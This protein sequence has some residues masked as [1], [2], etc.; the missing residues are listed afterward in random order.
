MAE[1]SGRRGKKQNY[2][3]N[4]Q[5]H[6]EWM[7]RKKLGRPETVIARAARIA[8]AHYGDPCVKCGVAHDEA[9]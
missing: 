5:A 4:P 7:R 6:D 2:N 9:D 1:G 8:G 3:K